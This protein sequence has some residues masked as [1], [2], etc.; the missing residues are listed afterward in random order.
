M[1]FETVCVVGLG[2]IGGSFARAIKEY[3]DARVLGLD[4]DESVLLAAKTAGTIDGIADSAS[5]AG[6]D[7]TLIALYPEATLD[8]IRENATVFKAGSIVCDT[9]GVKRVICDRAFAAARENGFHFVGTHPMAGTQFSGFA[10]SRATMFKNAPM[11]LLSAENEDLTLLGSL[12]DFFAALGFST[13]R[14]TTPEEHDRMIAYTSQLAHVVSNAYVRSETAQNHR[15]FSAGSYRDLTRVAR[16]NTDMWTQLFLDNR[17]FLADEIDTLIQNLTKYRDLIRSGDAE[18]LRG[19]LDI[20]CELK[21]RA[22]KIEQ[23]GKK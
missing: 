3:T 10:H 8:F 5:L 6:C 22:E 14:F 19:E 9:C 4:R 21:K 7:L 15:G 13:I 18:T 17:D 23:G 1:K 11:L 12:H 20:G 16:M 2:L